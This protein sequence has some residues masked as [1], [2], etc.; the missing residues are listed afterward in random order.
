MRTG[1]T[2]ENRTGLTQKFVGIGRER[3]VED[4]EIENS[5][6]PLLQRG[7][8][9]PSTTRHPVAAEPRGV[10][11]TARLRLETHVRPIVMAVRRK[12]DASRVCRTEA[13]KVGAKVED[14]HGSQSLSPSA[15]VPFN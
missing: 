2:K 5:R 9:S 4:Q 14:R 10:L 11:P 8:N 7:N 1:P 13:R 3:M 12:T 15:F 6:D